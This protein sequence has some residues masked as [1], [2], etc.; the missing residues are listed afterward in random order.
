MVIY[1]TAIV[2]AVIDFIYVYAFHFDDFSEEQLVLY[3][4]LWFLFFIFG[5][6]G[7]V[8]SYLKKQVDEGKYQDLREAL[9]HSSE[10]YGIFGPLRQLFFFPLIFINLKN[11]FL[12]TVISTLIWAG[13]LALFFLFIFPRM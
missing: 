12:L 1:I 2:L 3:S 13:L 4:P 5:I 9:V 7:W 11:T 6:Y 10:S 8:A